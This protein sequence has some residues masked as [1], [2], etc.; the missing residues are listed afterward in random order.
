MAG[1]YWCTTSSASCRS[2]SRRSWT[3]RWRGWTGSGMQR[4]LTEELAAGVRSLVASRLGL[5]FPPH[6][7]RELEQA[8]SGAALESGTHS[9][10]AFAERLLASPVAPADLGRLGRHLTIGETYFFRDDALFATLETQVLPRLIRAR[11]G[12]TRRLSVWSAGCSTGEEA[13]SLA[14]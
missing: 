5:A 6:R 8:L 13:Y 14:I 7:T 11:A 12:T 1:S 3:A 4:A 9:V 10:A 2:R